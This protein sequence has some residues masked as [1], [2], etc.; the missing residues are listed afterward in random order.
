MY[1][2]IFNLL[3]E[4]K[5]NFNE[6]ILNQVIYCIQNDFDFSDLYENESKSRE[7]LNG[8]NDKFYNELSI[9]FTNDLND[10]PEFYF[11][12]WEP[13]FGFFNDDT[14]KLFFSFCLD[15]SENTDA[16]EY[17]NGFIELD[18]NDSPEIAQYHFNRIDHYVSSYFIGLCYLYLDNY[19]N[20]I[21]QNEYFLSNLF[22]TVQSLNSEL[23]EEFDDDFLLLEWNIYADLGYLY[24]K[25]ENYNKANSNYNKSIEIFSLEDNY[26]INHFQFKDNKYSDFEIFVN[27]YIFTLEKIREYKKCLEIL[28]FA[29]QKF[30]N[31]LNYKSKKVRIEK[32]ISDIRYIDETLYSLLPTKKIINHTNFEKVKV[33][34]KEKVLEDLILEQI[35]NKYQVFGKP[36]EIYEDTKIHG[37]Q[38]YISSV[39]GYLDLLLIDKSTD[40]LYIVELKRNE[41]GV[42]VV[43][44]IEKYINGLSKELNRAIKGIICLHKPDDLL[45]DL[46]KTKPNI[47]LYTY[48]FD[49]KKI[50]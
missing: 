4:L 49:F 39:I 26:K 37:R 43:S 34:S 9:L 23:K 27:N 1:S 7:L 46:V 31:N 35:K 33:I 45:I 50:W 28:E 36:L 12:V 15:N 42:E 13:M 48:H 40:E 5:N 21:K 16:S 32:K 41:A 20:A 44:Q 18:I 38:Y 25:L 2:K 19:E 10:F 22:A 3:E 17:I 11:M 24:N 47:E 14:K 6:E 30:P 29:L 8:Q